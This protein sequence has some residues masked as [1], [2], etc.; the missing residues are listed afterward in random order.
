MNNMSGEFVSRNIEISVFN[1]HSAKARRDL[2]VPSQQ[3]NCGIDIEVDLDLGVAI[4]SLARCGIGQHRDHGWGAETP[5]APVGTCRTLGSSHPGA[6][7]WR[8]RMSARAV[9]GSGCIRSGIPLVPTRG[10]GD[11]GRV[12]LP[13]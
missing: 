2:F 10:L 7:V 6:T 4:W 12:E 9:R 8:F 1:Q 11:T 13:S 3:W 5:I